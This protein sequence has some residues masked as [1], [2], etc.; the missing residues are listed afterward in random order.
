MRIFDDEEF[1][2]RGLK[3][4]PEGSW[5]EAAD[6]ALI[7]GVKEFPADATFPLR[8]THI[9]FA[10]CYK[11]QEGWQKVLRRLVEGE[12]TLLDLEFLQDERGRR[13]AAFGYRGRFAGAALGILAWA[14]KVPGEQIGEVRAYDNESDLILHVKD[15]VQQV[16]HTGA[17][18]P[19]ILVIGALGRCGSGA[20]DC[21]QKLGIDNILQWE[22]SETARDGPFKEIVQSDV[23]I[24]CIYLNEQIPPFIDE[25]SLNTAE[26]RLSVVVDVS[27]DISNPFNP[28]PIY[29]ANTTFTNPTVRF[30]TSLGPELDVISID[31][32]PSLLPREASEEFSQALLNSLLQ[33]DKWRTTRVWSEAENLFQRKVGE[34]NNVEA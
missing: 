6:D 17:S 29:N 2:E 21:C 3:M 1:E 9:H 32:L 24:N 5:K 34:M 15:I 33:L 8:H 22:M 31:H 25:K 19:T 16:L 26:R 4:V 12:G 20:V 13:V 30:A 27:C 14:K 7:L 11:G 18:P 28:I 10:H 23:F